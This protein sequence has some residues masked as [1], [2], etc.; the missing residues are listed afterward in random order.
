MKSMVCNLCEPVLACAL[1]CGLG[2]GELYSLTFPRNRQ[3]AWERLGGAT[4]DRRLLLEG[5]KKICPPAPLQRSL[6][7]LPEEDADGGSY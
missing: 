4:E 3:R 7:N 5:I 1:A 2:G 6:G